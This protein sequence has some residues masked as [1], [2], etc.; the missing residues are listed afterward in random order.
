MYSFGEWISEKDIPG[1]TT[2]FRGPHEIPTDLISVRFNSNINVFKKRCEQLNDIPLNMAD[3][4]YGFEITSVLT[5]APFRWMPII[6]AW[7]RAR[8]KKQTG[9]VPRE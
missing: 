6:F 1:G 4:A 5:V 2:F 7:F 8:G 3:A 9:V